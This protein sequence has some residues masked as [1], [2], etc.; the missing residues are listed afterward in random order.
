MTTTMPRS[1]GNTVQTRA[2]L[3]QG[4][5][6]GDE[7]RWQ[8]FYR[9]YGPV[10]RGFALKAGLT[11]TEADEVVQ[12]TC[13]GVAR[14]VGEFRYDP[15]KCRFKTWLLNPASW[16]VKN[17]FTKRQRWDDRVHGPSGETP[18]GADRRPALPGDDP[19]RTATVERVADRNALPLDALWD[20]EWRAN[21][22]KAALD[23]VR[24]HFSPTQFQIFDLNVLKE[25]PAGDV[26]KSL[27]VSVA[28]VYLAKH[29]VSAEGMAGR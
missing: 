1:E 14:N 18:D 10:I 13:I 11:E 20:A 29:R 12:E 4:L 9:F 26:A 2:S 23:K 16:R 15:A 17:Q 5:Q 27:G 28:S 19:N 3:V 8:E 25:W 24:T 22:L 6:A 7:D 21:L